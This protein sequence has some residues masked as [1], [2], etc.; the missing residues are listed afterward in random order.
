MTKVVNIRKEQCDVYIGRPGA[1]GKGEFG[2]PFP[3]D[4]SG[5]EMCI[6]R[7]RNYFY[8]RINSDSAFKDKVLKLSGKTLGCFCKP[9]SCHGDVI[10]EYL[11]SFTETPNVSS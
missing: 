2:N 3:I 5:R 7:F 8:K 4:S 6:A 11:D 1:N 9:L 10:K